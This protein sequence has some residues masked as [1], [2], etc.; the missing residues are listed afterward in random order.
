M[1]NKFKNRYV[2]NL[3]NY[4]FLIIIISPFVIIFRIFKKKR[5][6]KDLLK[7][8]AYRQL[9]EGKVKLYGFMVLV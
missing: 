6:K 8:L 2:F 7:N 9:K 5:I 4:Y 1:K 3:S